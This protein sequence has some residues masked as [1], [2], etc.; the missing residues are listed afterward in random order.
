MKREGWRFGYRGRNRNKACKELSTMV[1]S[2]LFSSLFRSRQLA[3]AGQIESSR[4]RSLNPPSSPLPPPPHIPT[5][6]HNS[7]G[8][9]L[10]LAG[11]ATS[12][13]FVATNTCLSRQN[14]FCRDRNIFVATNICRSKQFCRAK[15]FLSRPA[16]FCIFFLL[17]PTIT[18]VSPNLILSRQKFC[19]AKTFLSG[20][21]FCCD[22]HTFANFLLPPTITNVS[23]NRDVCATE[24]RG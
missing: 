5:G 3:R 12:I 20:Q 21:F 22:K 7:Q 18:N 19:R 14:V 16:Y 17:P 13:I 11:A 4:Q 10:L 15:I 6:R 24:T 9:K 1:S 2:E 8:D 23:P